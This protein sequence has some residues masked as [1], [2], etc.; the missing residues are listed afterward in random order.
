MNIIVYGTS[1]ASCEKAR[2]WE[3][4]LLLLE[5]SSSETLVPNLITFNALLS[6]VSTE[7][8]LSG[9]QRLLFQRPLQPVEAPWHLAS[10]LMCPA[11]Q[12]SLDTVAM[13]FQGQDEHLEMDIV[14]S[15]VEISRVLDIV[16][17]CVSGSAEAT[18][19]F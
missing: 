5:A 6:A 18:T 11:F 12:S 13:R 1:V 16:P 3:R 14:S 15:S 19:P 9:D 8:R 17:N 7:G 4:A 10:Q 2:R